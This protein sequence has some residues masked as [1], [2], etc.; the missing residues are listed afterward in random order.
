MQT[1][2]GGP[3]W[4]TM[5]DGPAQIVIRSVAAD[6]FAADLQ[7]VFVNSATGASQA[8]TGKLSGSWQ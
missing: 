3:I 4:H 1:E 6:G 7:G 8:V 2:A 5:A